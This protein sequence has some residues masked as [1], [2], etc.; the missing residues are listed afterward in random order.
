MSPIEVR[1]ADWRTEQNPLKRIRTRVFI[2]E[3]GVPPS[4]EWDDADTGA[5]HFIALVDGHAVG[6]ARLLDDG[7]IGRMAVLSDWRR[8]GVGRALLEMAVGQARQR[9]DARVWLEAQTHAIGFYARQ[10]FITDG[11][12]FMDAGIAHRRMYRILS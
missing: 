3:Q 4:L 7:R 6:T 9:G 12:I 8:R 11:E 10:G 1:R 5:M 2:Q